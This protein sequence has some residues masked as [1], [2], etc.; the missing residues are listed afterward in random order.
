MGVSKGPPGF[1]RKFY[2]FH[3]AIGVV[4]ESST[5]ALEAPQSFRKIP[6]FSEEFDVCL[7]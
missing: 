7:F 4:S 5:E 3:I 2:G 6:I 1:T